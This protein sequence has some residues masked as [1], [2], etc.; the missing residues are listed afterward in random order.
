MNSPTI[1]Q[2][3]EWLA[4]YSA[5]MS[6]IAERESRYRTTLFVAG[7]LSIIVERCPPGTRGMTTYL[8]KVGDSASVSVLPKHLKQISDAALAAFNEAQKGTT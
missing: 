5:A 3:T 1:K 4:G 2:S 6:K 8:L 7:P